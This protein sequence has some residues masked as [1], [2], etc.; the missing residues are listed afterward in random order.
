MSGMYMKQRKVYGYFLTIEEAEAYKEKHN[1]DGEIKE[2]CQG[3]YKIV[4]K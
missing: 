2:T 3:N 1:I 4:V